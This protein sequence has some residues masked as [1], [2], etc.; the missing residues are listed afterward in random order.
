MPTRRQ[1]ITGMA[2]AALT[3]ATLRLDAAMEQVRPEV[4]LFSK[5]LQWL[6][7]DEMAQTAAEIGFDGVDLTVRPGGHVLPE[8][9][10]EDL[11]RAIRAVREAGLV[12]DRMTTAIVD[13]DDPLVDRI[14]GVAADQGIR[15]NRLGWLKY[16]QDRSLPPQIEA[17][18]SRM[19]RLADLHERH[20]L[21]GA[22][23]NHAGTE[24]GSP[25]WDAWLMVRD[26]DPR[27]L[28]IRYDVRHAV[29]EGSRSWELGLQLVAPHVRS[30]DIKDFRWIEESHGV[31]SVESVPLGQGAVPF[32]RYFNL[33]RQWHVNGGMTL[34]Y[35]YPLGGADKGKAQ[36][37]IP[38]N[39]VIAALRRDLDWLRRRLEAG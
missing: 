26:L 28:G 23:Q 10:A 25:V 4:H 11:P 24:V 34:H 14:L 22:Y 5:H 35:E 2:A 7:Y 9:V 37:S 8:R 19:E 30:L 33:L 12:A 32:D 18:R 27:W 39:Q 29:A 36:L 21:H 13:P 20:G 3:P 38:A 6:G 31:W 16:D 15:I 1:M 17:H